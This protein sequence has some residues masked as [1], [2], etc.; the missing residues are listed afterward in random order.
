MERIL[1]RVT[2]IKGGDID[3]SLIR[4][5]LLI[6]LGDIGDVILTFPCIRALKETLPAAKI[7]VAVYDSNTCLL[8]GCQWVDK[9][10]PIRKESGDI[11]KRLLDMLRFALHIRQAGYDTV[12]DLRTGDR[13]A[14]LT[15]LTGARYRI[16]FYGS[17]NKLW[18]NR[19]YTHLLYPDKSPDLHTVDYLLDLFNAYGIDASSHSPEYHVQPRLEARASHLLD[20][21]G[22]PRGRPVVAYHA[23][24]KWRYKGWGQAKHV[25][26]IK[27]LVERFNAVVVITGS[28]DQRQQADLIAKESNSVIFNL[29]GK[30]SLELMA[31]VLKRCRLSIGVDTAGGHIAAA[32]GTPSVSLFGPGNFHKWAPYG[33]KGKIV[34][35][36]LDCV[37][38]KKMGCQD[39]GISRCMDELT[40]DEVI[41]EIEPFVADVFRRGPSAKQNN[42]R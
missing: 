11:A 12:F 17:Y 6:Q 4:K 36:K 25:A 23:F 31:A 13:G 37:P 24:S 14:I 29:A 18:R 40:V 34:Y 41:N 10:V 26:L 22:V 35:K 28:Q 1:S 32:V 39:S 8:D 21:I 7:A 5:I 19:I 38:C 16:S 33:D 2:R 30:T 42:T 15:L 27:W 9:I 3:L 20:D